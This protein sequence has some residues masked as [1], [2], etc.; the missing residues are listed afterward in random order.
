MNDITEH[1]HVRC[2]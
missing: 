1:S 2:V